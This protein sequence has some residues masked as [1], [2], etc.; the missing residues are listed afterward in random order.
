MNHHAHAPGGLDAA[1]SD[2][3]ATVKNMRAGRYH[4]NEQEKVTQNMQTE[5][6]A[7][8]GIKSILIKYGK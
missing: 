1:L 4:Y 5:L 7:Q 2:G 3:C 8:K 6:G